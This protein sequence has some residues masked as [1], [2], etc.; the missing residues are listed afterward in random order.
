VGARGGLKPDV[1]AGTLLLMDD[2]GLMTLEDAIAAYAA[3]NI[4]FDPLGYFSLAKR[5]SY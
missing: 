4:K 3:E 1:P 2:Q 5:I